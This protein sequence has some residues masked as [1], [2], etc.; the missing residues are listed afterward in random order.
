M[1][2]PTIPMARQATAATIR[3]IPS[4]SRRTLFRH[5]HLPTVII[6]LLCRHRLLFEP[7]PLAMDYH[8]YGS[9]DTQSQVFENQKI[10]EPRVHKQ[11][12]LARIIR[13][14]IYF[15]AVFIAGFGA[16]AAVDSLGK[17]NVAVGIGIALLFGLFIAG[18]VVFFLVRRFQHIRFVQFLLGLFVST[19]CGIVA[20]ILVY[21]I[22]GD[23][24]R[25]LPSF[26]LS[27][28]IL[29]YG[30]ILAVLALW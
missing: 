22:F 15:V 12:L 14:I 30:L 3:Q 4:I 11:S 29:L 13:G 17:N 18:T 10:H 27:I 2:M 23:F 6:Y 21:A 20:L 1:N 5:H 28:I 26:L 8:S 7:P 25:T 16:F 24:S 9:F 19:G